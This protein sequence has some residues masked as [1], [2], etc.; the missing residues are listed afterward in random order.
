MEQNSFGT[1]L[2]LKWVICCTL[3]GGLGLVGIEK[4]LRLKGEMVDHFPKDVSIHTPFS[5]TEKNLLDFMYGNEWKSKSGWGKNY[6]MSWFGGCFGRKKKH[7]R[8]VLAVWDDGFPFFFIHKKL[9]A[10]L[11]FSHLPQKNNLH[12]PLYT[13]CEIFVLLF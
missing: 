1:M 10:L 11:K 2:S 4:W 3:W 12:P 8:R 7:G 9:L 6:G 13:E 5:I